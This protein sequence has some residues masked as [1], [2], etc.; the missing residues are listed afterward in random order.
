MKELYVVAVLRLNR[1]LRFTGNLVKRGKASLSSWKK[2]RR[3]VAQVKWH[4]GE[5]YL[6]VVTNL[7]RPADQVVSFYNQRGTA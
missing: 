1:C 4:L 5:L 7:P 6:F 2:P 3:V